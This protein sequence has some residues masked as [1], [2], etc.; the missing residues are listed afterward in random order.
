MS[1]REHE[2]VV[3]VERTEEQISEL[4]GERVNAG[5]FF[6]KK[7]RL[8]NEQMSELRG[9]GKKIACHITVME[10]DE[11]TDEEWEV[12]R[13]DCMNDCIFLVF[14]V[15]APIALGLVVA[16]AVVMIAIWNR[17]PCA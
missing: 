12:P 9:G 7:V 17:C 16:L 5:H 11:S 4:K 3:E 6:F 14:V 8:A 2:D 1:E 10:E 15:P 13:N